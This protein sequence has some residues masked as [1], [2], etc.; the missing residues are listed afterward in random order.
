[1]EKHGLRGSSM[2]RNRESWSE[3]PWGAQL[4]MG[5]ALSKIGVA[6]RDRRHSPKWRSMVRNGGGESEREGRQR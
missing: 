3:T 6:V 1:M 5:V 2:V 4:E